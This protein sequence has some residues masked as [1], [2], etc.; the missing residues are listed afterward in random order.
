MDWLRLII[1]F[2]R[3]CYFPHSSA[4]FIKENIPLNVCN[5][6]YKFCFERHPYDKFI[7]RFYWRN[8]H[9]KLNFDQVV[10]EYNHDKIGSKHTDLYCINGNL[11]VDKIYKYEEMEDS[12]H[13]LTKRLNLKKP[14]KLLKYRA[15]G[16]FRKDHKRSS[17]FLSDDQKNKIFEIDSDVFTIMGYER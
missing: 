5:S 13:D 1:R 4:G 7:S 3:K 12:L 8:K 16:S 2:R 11:A 15:K 9:N 17:E 10:N 6:Y 14:L